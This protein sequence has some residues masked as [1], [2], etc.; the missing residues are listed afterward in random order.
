MRQY[1]GKRIDNG[2]WVY[3]NGVKTPYGTYIIPQNI[4]ANNM[5]QFAVDPK[6]VGQYTGL[7]DVEQ[8]DEPKELFTSDIVSMHQF[9]F[10]GDEY[11]NE[12]IGVLEYDEELA[13]VCLTKMKHDG[14][15]RY[16]GCSDQ[17]E[18]ANEKIP[19]CTIIGLHE[20]SWTHKGNVFDNPELL[21]EGGN[22][23]GL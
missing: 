7:Q 6:T 1:R 20:T 15:R 4:I 2:E 11:E 19:V 5:P 14:I 23:S 3:G 17:D 18:F 21:G 10:D 8:F 13:C 22:K 9:L 12:I 16:M